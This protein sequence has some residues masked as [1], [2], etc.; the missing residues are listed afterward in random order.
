MKRTTP[1]KLLMIAALLALCLLAFALPASMAAL[2]GDMDKDGLITAADARIVLRI[3]VGLEKVEDYMGDGPFNGEDPAE[4]N[5]EITCSISDD[6]YFVGGESRAVISVTA[7]ANLSAANLKI[8]DA[9]NEEVFA[10]KISSLKKGTAATV[11]WDGKVN[12]TDYAPSGVYT[13]CVSNGKNEA[14]LEGL[15]F[16]AKNYF[17]DG[18]GSEAHPFPVASKEDF[19]NVVR[20]PNAHFKQTKDIDY[21]YGANPS[22]F[23]EDAPF[24]GTYDGNGKVF[25]NIV[26]TNPLFNYVGENGKIKKLRVSDCSFSSRAVLTYKNRGQITSCDFNVLQTYNSSETIS[27]GIICAVNSGLIMNCNVEGVFSVFQDNGRG[28]A[29]VGNICDSNEGRIMSCSTNVKL[30]ASVNYGVTACHVGCIVATNQPTGFIQNCE[31]KGTVNHP[32]RVPGG[33]ASLNYG[34]IISCIYTGES[35]VNLVGGGS[36]IVA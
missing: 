9:A 20:Y 35:D 29:W 30:T 7:D 26:S 32:S 3:A 1:K 16:T 19:A 33:I 12:K 11:T 8:V 31:A 2:P 14:K 22:M 4:V 5:F 25:K 21:A 10:Q 17:G 27:A 36:G 28:S 6:G 23:T 34:Q 13:I 15:T 24:N 18:N